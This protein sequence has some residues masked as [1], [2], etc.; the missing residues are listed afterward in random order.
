MIHAIAANHLDRKFCPI[1]PD[2]AWA[3]DITTI[4]TTDGLRYLAVWMDL[5]LRRI[6]RWAL[7]E[8][9]ESALVTKA[10]ERAFGCRSF[11]LDELVN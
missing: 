8:T 10:L 11:N 1:R 4:D 5:H 9:L 2:L 6:I 3:G 7:G